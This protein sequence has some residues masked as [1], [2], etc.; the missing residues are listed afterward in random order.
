MSIKDIQVTTNELAD[1]LDVDPKYISQ[2]VLNHSYPKEDHNSFSLYDF[3]KK[4]FEH[5]KEMC[6]D[7]VKKVREERTRDRYERASAELKEMEVEKQKGKLVNA[8]DVDSAWKDAMQVVINKWD[9]FPT[10]VAHLLVGIDDVKQIEII[11]TEKK[12]KVKADI[13][14]QTLHTKASIPGT[15]E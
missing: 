12:N 11:L 2:L 4:R 10:M 6:D 1:L 9:G 3:I 7:R 13:A 15:A 14:K 8:D 5:L